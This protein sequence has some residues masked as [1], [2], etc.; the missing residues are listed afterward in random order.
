MGYKKQADILKAVKE[1]KKEDKL[2][3]PLKPIK[4]EDF[5]THNDSYIETSGTGKVGSVQARYSDLVRLFGE[6][7][8]ESTGR[9]HFRVNWTIRWRDGIVATV[10]DWGEK[11]VP[12]E[13]V[14][15]WN[16]GGESILSLWRVQEELEV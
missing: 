13:E 15:S 1:S 2:V 11:Q 8:K 7:E 10:Y 14:R 6:P 9:E 16:V 12:L 3:S 4:E 5:V